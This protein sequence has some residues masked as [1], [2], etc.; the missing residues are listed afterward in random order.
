MAKWKYTFNFVPI[1][2][3]HDNGNITLQELGN[4]ISETIKAKVSEDDMYFY[5]DDALLRMEIVETV[6]DFDD[7]LNDIYDWGDTTLNA[8]T[9]PHE[10]MAWIGFAG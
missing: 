4:K 8:S 3:Q 10:K 2:R 6:E 1:K 9:W 7:A 5:L